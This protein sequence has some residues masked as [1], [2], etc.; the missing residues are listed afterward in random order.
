MS[1]S[2]PDTHW[3]SQAAGTSALTSS[4]LKPLARRQGLIVGLSGSN[5]GYNG[6][7]Q[8]PEIR[9]CLFYYDGWCHA[10][11]LLEEFQ[12]PSIDIRA[13]E[14]IKA[15]WPCLTMFYLPNPRHPVCVCRH[16]ESDCSVG[17]ALDAH[18]SSLATPKFAGHCPLV[19][20]LSRLK[21][22]KLMRDK[23]LQIHKNVDTDYF[24]I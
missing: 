19:D 13:I 18:C 20:T 16:Y 22:T 1:G 17:W 9:G 6:H 8:P 14:L 11:F 12:M 21:E 10:F 15:V 7:L 3:S 23:S 24:H 2:F 4:T 5:S